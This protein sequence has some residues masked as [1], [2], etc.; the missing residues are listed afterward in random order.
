[1]RRRTYTISQLVELVA[2]VRPTPLATAVFVK[3]LSGLRRSDRLIV[4]PRCVI[5]ELRCHYA[6]QRSTRAMLGLPDGPDLVFCEPGG[7][8]WDADT[9]WSAFAY[10]M[11]KSTLPR[12]SLQ[13]L[14]HS[15]GL[16]RRSQEILRECRRP[17]IHRYR[18]Q[19]LRAEE[20]QPQPFARHNR[21]R[22]CQQV[23]LVEF[24]GHSNC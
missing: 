7:T 22:E 11:R 6:E 13:E 24:P 12:I 15:Y 10:P 23:L 16:E 4:L 5:E 17:G 9:F 19:L 2:Y 3:A 14:R 18:L 1:L 20:D 8:L 21:H